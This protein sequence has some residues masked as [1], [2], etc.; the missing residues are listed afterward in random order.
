[1][2]RNR[3]RCVRSD[4]NAGGDKAQYRPK[5]KPFEQDHAERR[6]RKKDNDSQ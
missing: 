3:S 4:Y 1:M 6:Y 2:D 5:T